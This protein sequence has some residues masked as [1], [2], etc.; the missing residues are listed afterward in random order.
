MARL[1]TSAARVTKEEHDGSSSSEEEIDYIRAARD[2]GDMSLVRQ[3]LHGITAEADDT[4]HENFGRYAE[5]IALG[6][7]LWQSEALTE[8]E[9]ACIDPAEDGYLLSANDAKRAV[10]QHRK[11]AKCERTAPFAHATQPHSRILHIDY[12]KRFEDW[13]ARLLTEEQ[14]PHQ[15]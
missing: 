10:L 2:I 3:T 5:S 7:T 9:I 14:Q 4:G 15:E 11:D 8:A 13:F 6:R 12:A 1:L